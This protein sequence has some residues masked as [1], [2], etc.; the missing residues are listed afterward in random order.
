MKKYLDM[1]SWNR[2]AHYEHFNRF[3]DPYFSVVS[4][5]DV[6]K[7]YQYSRDT[8]ISFFALYLH[9]CMKAVNAVENLRYRIEDDK[10]VIHK[11]INASATILREDN[12]FGCSFIHFSEDFDVFY[13]NLNK[14][15]ERIFNSKDLFPPINSED[16][17]YCSSLPWFNFTGHKEP[18]LGVKESVPKIAFAK[19]EKKE[20][21]LLMPV[22]IAV[23]HAL[24]DGY[25]LGLFF[26][27]YQEEL[28]KIG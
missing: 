18:Y 26:K 14:E 21:K 8:G 28:D 22:A 20:D 7:A 5:V 2:K 19:I 23:N 3:A 13:Q 4:D 25:H 10:V 6:T 27:H 9:T 16:C 24:V 15:K 12:T 1:E 17:I 11:V